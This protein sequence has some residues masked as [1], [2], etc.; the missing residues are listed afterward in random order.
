MTP[1]RL[2]AVSASV[3]IVVAAVLVTHAA[4]ASTSYD[5]LVLIGELYSGP[6]RG[7]P[8]G[9]LPITR[10]RSAPQPVRPWL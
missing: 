8:H 6:Q 7:D 3:V 1:S 5:D 2:L 4:G 10:S 9:W